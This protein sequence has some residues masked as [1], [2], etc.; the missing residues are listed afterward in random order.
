M[1]LLNFW[2]NK[3]IQ[4]NFSDDNISE[5]I[6]KTDLLCQTLINNGYGFYVDYL[7]QIRMSAENKNESKFRELVISRELFGGS[8]ALWEIDIQDSTEYQK[9]NI[10]FRDYINLITLMGIKNGRIKQIQKIMPKLR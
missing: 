6:K 5:L 4:I 3:K 9:F 8:G 10:Q 2:I 7:T 1:G